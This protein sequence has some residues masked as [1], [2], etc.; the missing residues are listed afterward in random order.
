V[1]E[2]KNLHDCRCACRRQARQ[3]QWDIQKT[4]LSV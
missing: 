4:V 3:L 1:P 2:D